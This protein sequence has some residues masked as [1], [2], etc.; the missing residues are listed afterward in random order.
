M[1]VASST[2]TAP[3]LHTAEQR[4]RLKHLACL[5]LTA[6]GAEVLSWLQGLV[7]CGDCPVSCG[8]S[9][10]VLLTV[11]RVLCD[12]AGTARGVSQWGLMQWCQRRRGWGVACCYWVLDTML[13]RVH[14]CHAAI[15]G[16]T[17]TCGG[18]AGCAQFHMTTY[19]EKCCCC[20]SHE[21][22]AGVTAITGVLWG[23]LAAGRRALM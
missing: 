1:W 18:C 13:A 2:H 7:L 5:L 9:R 3:G 10:N 16:A 17:H 6:T 11:Q 21:P 4:G 23:S 19:Q 15:A 20:E 12:A 14:M 8:W 22:C